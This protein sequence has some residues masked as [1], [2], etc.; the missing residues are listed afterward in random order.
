MYLLYIRPS[1]HLCT[2]VHTVCTHLPF[3]CTSPP[4]S[5]TSP[6]L[7]TQK[8]A[9]PLAAHQAFVPLTLSSKHAS[10]IPAPRPETQRTIMRPLRSPPLLPRSTN[11]ELLSNH[12]MMAAWSLGRPLARSPSPCMHPPFAGCPLRSCEL[13]TWFHWPQIQVHM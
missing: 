2:H 7:V 10:P 9:H 4:Q 12:D 6:R 1:I 8:P 13:H 3:T 5:R 11:H